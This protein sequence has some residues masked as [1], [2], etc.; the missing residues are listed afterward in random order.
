MNQPQRDYFVQWEQPHL[1]VVYTCINGETIRVCHVDLH[2]DPV[3]Q[4]PEKPWH[5]R[6]V[7]LLIAHG[8]LYHHCCLKRGS[9]EAS[10]L[11]AYWRQD[12]AFTAL[13]SCQDLRPQFTDTFINSW[14]VDCMLDELKAQTAILRRARNAGLSIN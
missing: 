12:F 11:A 3:L 5:I 4:A 8:I 7:S 14:L 2:K 6:R 13:E 10:L 1:V 9:S